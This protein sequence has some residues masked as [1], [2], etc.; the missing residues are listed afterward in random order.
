MPSCL[1]NEFDIPRHGRSQQLVESILTLDFSEGDATRVEELN[2]KANEGQLT[3]SDRSELEAYANLANLLA[4]W[5]SRCKTNHT[6]NTANKH[7]PTPLQEKEE[8]A[9]PK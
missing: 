2:E 5:Q 6:T 9:D 8:K 4:Y 1:R 3:Y 7:Q